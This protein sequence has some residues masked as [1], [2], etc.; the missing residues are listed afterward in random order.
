LGLERC[1]QERF[2]EGELSDSGDTVAKL[3]L[4]TSHR[5]VATRRWHRRCSRAVA[6]P[7]EWWGHGVAKG[8]E[9]VGGLGVPPGGLTDSGVGWV[10]WGSAVGEAGRGASRVS[11]KDSRIEN[12]KPEYFP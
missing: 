6:P 3:L 7:T 12:L 1:G 4:A 5:C 8:A 2:L 9:V 11:C 10:G